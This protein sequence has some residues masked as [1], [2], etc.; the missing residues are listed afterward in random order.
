L[1][2]GPEHSTPF[3][4][5]YYFNQRYT[6]PE[7]ALHWTAELIEELR[8]KSRKGEFI[9]DMPCFSVHDS[10]YKQTFLLAVGTYNGDTDR[11]LVSV[12]SALGPRIAGG[13]GLVVGSEK[14]WCEV[15]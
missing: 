1:F 11:A 4:Q 15:R 10:Y 8:N 5:S 3:T 9:G 13:H 7:R 2:I 14:P 6:G 12:L